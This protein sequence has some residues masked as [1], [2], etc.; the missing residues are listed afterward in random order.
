METLLEKNC[1]DNNVAGLN[2]ETLNGD[3]DKIFINAPVARVT[4]CGFGPFRGRL[5]Q[6]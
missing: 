4:S 3:F 1:L 2:D 5:F 6:K